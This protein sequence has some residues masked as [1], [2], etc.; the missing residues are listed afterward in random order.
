GREEKQMLDLF[1][2]DA[3]ESIRRVCKPVQRC[4]T[5]SLALARLN[6][7][8]KLRLLYFASFASFASFADKNALSAPSQQPLT[9]SNACP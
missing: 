5:D 4:R 3:P 7:S 2:T 9:W 6:S 1:S 8:E